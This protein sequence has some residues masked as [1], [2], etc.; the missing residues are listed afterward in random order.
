MS[1]S[2]QNRP[3]LFYRHLATCNK[4]FNIV[5]LGSRS[6]VFVFYCQGIM[7]L[8]LNALLYL[9]DTDDY[10]NNFYQILVKYH[11]RARPNFLSEPSA[12][13]GSAQSARLGFGSAG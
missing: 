6:Q 8:L 3:N 13:F 11:A 2:L 5:E 4:P 12:R 1:K 10:Y 7:D 9:L